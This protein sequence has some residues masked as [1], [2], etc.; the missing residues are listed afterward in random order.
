MDHVIE[1]M[2]LM[3]KRMC[4]GCQGCASICP[5]NAITMHRDEEGFLYPHISRKRCVSCGLCEKTCPSLNDTEGTH[6]SDEAFAYI[7]EN[8][9]IRM[10]SSS[11]GVFTELSEWIFS[12]QGWVYGAKFNKDWLV[13]HV[14]VNNLDD[15]RLLRGAKYLQSDINLAYRDVK[16]HL[17]NEEWVM[18]TGTP[19]QINGLRNYLGKDYKC[20]LL[21]DVICHGTPS[22]KVWGAYLETIAKNKVID[23]FMRDKSS[24]W[25]SYNLCIKFADGDKLLIPNN[26]CLFMK[27]FLSDLYLRPSCYVCQSKGEKRSSDLTIADFWGI[28]NVDASMNDHKGTSLVI[29]HTD[30]G[31]QVIKNLRGKFKNEDVMMA[32]KDNPSYFQP[33][34]VNSKRLE[35]FREFTGNPKDIQRIIMKYTKMPFKFRMLSGCRRVYDFLKCIFSGG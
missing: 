27:G 23:V 17:L 8:D 13:K 25:E 21:V 12:L 34:K 9:Y 28:E 15:L 4:T 11:G 10:I 19:C 5:K 20:L 6:H 7:N 22:P 14:A 3:D 31:R 32:L 35:F 24:S 16:K 29:V 2:I 18:F 30:K 26:K 33:A 1:K